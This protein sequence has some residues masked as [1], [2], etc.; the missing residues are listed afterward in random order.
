ML[1]KLPLLMKL[2]AAAGCCWCDECQCL[3]T[4]LTMSLT[5]D[6]VDDTA[7]YMM[8]FEYE[9]KRQTEW[10]WWWWLFVNDIWGIHQVCSGIVVVTA[11]DSESGHPGSNP[12]WRQYTM[13]L[14]SLHRAYSSLHPSGVVHWVPEQLNIK[15]VT[16]ACKLINGCS[17]VLCLATPS[18]VSAG[19]PQK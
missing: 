1:Q 7:D 16:G 2:A 11:Y 5:A 10:W 17:L 3:W 9:N 13:R 8:G 4:T 19:M 12:E 6:Y 15:A 14:R 18:V